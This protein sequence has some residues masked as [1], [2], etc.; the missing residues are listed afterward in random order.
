MSKVRKSFVPVTSDA[1]MLT[2]WKGA[3]LG[4]AQDGMY[5]AIW[6]VLIQIL[7]VLLIPLCTLVVEERSTA[8]ERTIAI[9]PD[10]TYAGMLGSFSAIK[11]STLRNSRSEPEVGP[12]MSFAPFASEMSSAAARADGERAAVEGGRLMASYECL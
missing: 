7:M 9:T 5:M 11:P 10:Q 8:V 4:W 6:S 3:P 12:V 2:N 1:M